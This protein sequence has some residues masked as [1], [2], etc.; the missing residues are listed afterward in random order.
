MLFY[1]PGELYDFKPVCD[2]L[3]IPNI[4]CKHKDMH[5]RIYINYE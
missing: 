1:D 3:Q 2:M 5:A 4:L